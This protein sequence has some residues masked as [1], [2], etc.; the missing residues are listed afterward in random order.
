MDFVSTFEDDAKTLRLLSGNPAKDFS[1]ICGE[2]RSL[3]SLDRKNYLY[4]AYCSVRHKPIL[5]HNMVLERV[6]KIRSILNQANQPSDMCGPRFLLRVDDF[7]RWDHSSDL[8]LQFHRC[9]SKYKIPYL[10]GVIPFPSP[11]PLSTAPQSVRRIKDSDIDL[12]RHLRGS[13]FEVAMHGFS[14]QTIGNMRHSEFVGAN[15]EEMAMNI[16]AGL[17]LFHSENLYPQ[18]FMPP[19]NSLDPA[20]FDL[21]KDY[22]HVITGGQESVLN[23]GL[24]LS[25]CYIHGVVY[26]P[27]YYPAYGRSS[28]LLQFVESLSHINEPVVVPLTL[29]WAWEVPDG[30]AGLER[31]CQRLE[32]RVGSWK[33]FLDLI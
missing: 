21:L 17:E 10:L 24:K 19:F 12:L 6:L 31:L 22:F 26:L 32:G 4:H 16:K 29:H 33:S 7:P 15:K 30:F 18:V 1:L 3:L 23:L 11:S 2:Y 27:S 5:Y 25:P 14:H 13:E 8:F 20:S 9:L 28:G